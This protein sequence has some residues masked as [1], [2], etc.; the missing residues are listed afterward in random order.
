ML[1]L[2]LESSPNADLTAV[3]A[4]VS[5]NDCS[6]T[7]ALTRVVIGLTMVE[8]GWALR[9]IVFAE[10]VS[11]LIP[12][13]ATI[14]P[15]ASDAIVK[16]PLE[17]V[18]AEGSPVSKTPF[19]L[20]SIKTVASFTNPS[21]TTPVWLRGADEPPPP[22]PAASPTRTAPAPT[23]TGVDT[24]RSL[25]EAPAFC[26]ARAGISESTLDDA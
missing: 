5:V 6:T 23:S 4:A 11:I 21:C 16:V 17:S 26:T 7:S 22:P 2:S 3:S 9:M 12:P 14:G 10:P 8:P 20:T 19:L 1:R 25:R 15:E 13:V 18:F 24:L